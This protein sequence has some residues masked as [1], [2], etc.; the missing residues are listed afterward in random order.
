MSCCKWDRI[1][2]L[3]IQIHNLS[4]SWRPAFITNAVAW[5]FL[6]GVPFLTN[7]DPILQ[8]NYFSF[9]YFY[10][11]S[12]SN[13]FCAMMIFSLPKLFSWRS[14][15]IFVFSV[16]LNTLYCHTL[17]IQCSSFF[18]QDCVTQY[19]TIHTEYGSF[20][21]CIFQTKLGLHMSRLI[22][23]NPFVETSKRPLAW[24]ISAW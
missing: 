13:K 23:T 24:R 18:I 8:F 15:W 1:S 12:A 2:I 20:Q 6:P 9:L 4:I 11:L 14:G 17:L 7:S 3:D 5:G 19:D 22:N 10:S 21:V 16:L